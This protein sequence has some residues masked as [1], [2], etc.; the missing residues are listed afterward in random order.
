MKLKV[1]FSYLICILINCSFLYSQVIVESK[2]EVRNIEFNISD[3]KLI[4]T[5][6]LVNTKPKE[7][8]TINVNI[9]ASSGKKVS[10][11]HLSGDVNEGVK[12]GYSKRIIW[13]IPEDIAFLDENIYVEING[14][15]QNPRI[16]KPINK[17]QGLLMSTFYPGWGST[18]L[19]LKPVHIFKGVLAYGC[20]AVS[21]NAGIQ[22]T[23]L[24]DDYKNSIDMD[25]R[26]RL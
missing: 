11:K 18:R 6:D 14:V 10:V 24:L 12:G 21:I 16:I 23:N 4:I 26:D 5:Y 17:G 8:F 7:L 13:D 15:H 9:I 2:A 22:S 20:L 3:E 25:E 1:L 19:T